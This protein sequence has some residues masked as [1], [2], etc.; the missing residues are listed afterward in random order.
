MKDQLLRELEKVKKKYPQR[1]WRALMIKDNDLNFTFTFR[2]SIGI[3][4]IESNSYN[5]VIYK[6][7]EQN[8]LDPDED[9]PLTIGL[10]VDEEYFMMSTSRGLLWI[11]KYG[12]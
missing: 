2:G 1:K 4:T 6:L 11:K 3:T 7:I 5:G 9:Y 12:I 8:N 10:I